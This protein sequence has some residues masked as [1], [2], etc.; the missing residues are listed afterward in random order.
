ME[1]EDSKG[2]KYTKVLVSGVP[3]IQYRGRTMMSLRDKEITLDIIDAISDDKIIDFILNST[4]LTFGNTSLLYFYRIFG[5]D[6]FTSGIMEQT[7]TVRQNDDTLSVLFGRYSNGKLHLKIEM[8]GREIKYTSCKSI[9][10]E[11]SRCNGKIS[12]YLVSTPTKSARN[13]N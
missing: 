4:F 13:F 11:H 3:N 12:K 2:R 9:P 1:F 5:I 10:C 8:N 7:F 6:Y